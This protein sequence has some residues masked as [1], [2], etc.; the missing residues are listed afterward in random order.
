[1]HF[2]FREPI[3]GQTVCSF[4]QRVIKLSLKDGQLVHAD[5]PNPIFFF[6]KPFKDWY[7]DLEDT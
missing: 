6:S 5:P 1:M 2:A 4:T 7:G 3:E